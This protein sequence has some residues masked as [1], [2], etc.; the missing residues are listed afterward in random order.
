MRPAL[1]PRAAEVPRGEAEAVDGRAVDGRAVDG[2]PGRWWD[3][4]R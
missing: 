4:P 2:V 1:A 3:F